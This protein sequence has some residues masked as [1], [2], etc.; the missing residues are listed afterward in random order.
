M[1]IHFVCK[2]KRSYV[3]KSSF[4]LDKHIL[5]TFIVIKTIVLL[6]LAFSFQATAKVSAQT[7]S[8]TLKNATLSSALEQ[9]G[10]QTKYD[11]SYNDRILKNARPVN[12]SLQNE[13]L[14]TSLQLLFAEQQLTY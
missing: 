12:I 1:N 6:V 14:E 10:K 11:F 2:E 13:T 8:L 5:K 7:I 9:I 3:M 4:H